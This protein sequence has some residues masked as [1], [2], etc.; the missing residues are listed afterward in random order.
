MKIMVVTGAS[1]GLGKE[2][3]KYFAKKNF[4]VCAI[5]RS[6]DKL[7]EIADAYPANIFPYTCDVSNAQQVKDVF[8]KI[9]EEH[10]QIDILINNAGVYQED[11][12]FPK[13]PFE[14]IDLTIDVN[15]KGTMYCSYAATQ[16][17]LKRKDG[18]IINIASRSGVYGNPCGPASADDSIGFGDYAASKHG[19]MGFADDFGRGLLANG[20]Y[21]TSLCPGG[22]RTPM[23]AGWNID[24]EK[25]IQPEQIADLIDFIIKQEKNILFKNMLFIPPHEWH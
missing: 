11:K 21:M 7:A 17:M 12:E 18:R 6:A 20:I 22:I 8:A 9:V 24:P 4:A 13:D 16:D 15:L 2:L 25:L 3:T 5:A 23:S 19:V 1:S 14:C 10:K